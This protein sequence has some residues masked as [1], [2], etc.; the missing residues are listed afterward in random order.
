MADVTLSNIAN[1]TG[2]YDAIP[3]TLT[4]EAVITEMI[5]ELTIV[6]TADK[7]NCASGN[8]AYTVTISNS[9][10]NPFKKPTF[11]DTLDPLLISLVE[12]S[13]KVNGTDANYTYDSE[14]GLL[15][16]ELETIAKDGSTE[17]TFQVQKV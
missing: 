13:V 15:T 10:E 12:N 9:A 2:D 4:S 11:T 14:T 6:K 16:V 8:L 1:V 5:A 7:Q 3:T 17:I